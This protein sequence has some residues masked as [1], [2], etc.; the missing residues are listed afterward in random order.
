MKKVF[1]AIVLLFGVVLGALFILPIVFKG[2]IKEAVHSAIDENVDAEVHF[3]E[4]AF[5]VSLISSFP[6]L[7]VGLNGLTV[8]NRAPFEGDTLVHID[9]FNIDVNVWKAISGEIA[10]AG[11][12]LYNP[13]INVKVLEDGRANYDIAKGTDSTVVEENTDELV[14][15]EGAKMTYILESF[16]IKNAHI[17][18]VDATMPTAIDID[19]FNIEGSAHMDLV[20]FDLKFLIEIAEISASYDKVTYLKKNSFMA[21]MTI[22]MDLENMKFTFKENHL[23]LNEFGFHFDGSVEM[24]TDDVKVDVTFGAENTTFKSVL[25]LVPAVFMEGFEEMKTEGSFEFGGFVKGIYNEETLPGYKVDLVVKDGLFQYPDLPTAVKN[26]QVD[27]HVDGSDGIIDNTI[28]DVKN[29]NMDLGKNPVHGQVKIAG[30][31]TMHVDA[32][33]KAA[34]NLEELMTMFPIDSL[35]MKGNFTAHILAH[36]VYDSATQSIPTID[37]EL[38]LANGYIKYDAYPLPMEEIHF[39]THVNNTTSKLNDTRIAVETAGLKIGEE[40]MEMDG[41]IYNLDNAHYKF[42]L[43]GG[44]NLADVEKVMPLDGMSMKGILKADMHAAGNM[45]LV[46][47]EAYDKLTTKGKVTLKNFIFEMDSTPPVGISYAEINMTSKKLSLDRY[48]GTV[49]KSDMKLKGN[50]ENYIAY[51]MTDHGVLKGVLN[52]NSNYFDVNE[53]M[54]DDEEEV[55]TAT[56]VEEEPSEVAAVP[57]N[58]DFAFKAN[59]KKIDMMDMSI[60][61]LLGTIIVRN[62][63]VSLNRSSFNLLDAKFTTTGQYN[64]YNPKKPY[65]DFDMGIK[66]L[67]FRKAYQTFNTVKKLAP[68]AEN[69]DGDCDMKLDIKGDI[70]PGYSPVYQ[71][72]NGNGRVDIQDAKIKDSDAL[73][74]IAK[75][76]KIKD[77]EDPKIED[78]HAKFVIKDG[79][80]T[81][82]PFGFKIAGMKATVSG[83]NSFT[84]ELDYKVQ[85]DV[86]ADKLSAMVPAQYRAILGDDDIP[87]KMNVK[88]TYDNRKISVDQETVDYILKRA[89]NKSSDELKDS[90][91]ELLNNL[92]DKNKSSDQ[93]KEAVDEGKKALKKLFGGK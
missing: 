55:E 91:K 48:D 37:T 7:R 93:K 58:I 71:T 36:G 50:I 72:L 62:G 88:G 43:V 25:S 45:E 2:D 39:L 66:D 79:K 15:E 46:E 70:G 11:I 77:F 68:L 86:P 9:Q 67:S 24:P 64:T 33:V 31:T 90:G 41:E 3:D 35:T 87:V 56:V 20:N 4:H 92:L 26:I 51:A 5:D 16:E 32:D 30:L 22:G 81:F 82:E 47:A 14:E 61:Q 85:T 10:L 76:T 38:K 18:Y 57:K 17:A 12:G 83:S 52:F 75:V 21:D 6:N 89:L 78:V 54:S 28:V 23:A 53:W 1:I 8:I 49:G 13:V 19:N 40:Q 59:M 73:D 44:F 34:L 80:L 42:D 69:I 29:F 60:E 84:G 27:M 74:Q 63:A 65:F